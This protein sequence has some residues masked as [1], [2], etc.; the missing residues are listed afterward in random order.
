MPDADAALAVLSAWETCSI[1]RARDVLGLCGGD[2][3]H[4]N[5]TLT[6]M[7]ALGHL[8]INWAN[9]TIRVQPPHLALLPTYGPPRGVLCGFRTPAFQNSISA[10]ISLASTVLPGLP[11]RITATAETLAQLGAW[12]SKHG[13]QMPP[14]PPA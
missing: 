9:G 8:S 14:T 11:S 13:L 1:A 7:Q 10:G 4:A 6:W 2:P 3:D 12:A 5:R